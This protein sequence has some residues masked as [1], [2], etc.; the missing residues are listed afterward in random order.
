[1][2]T[3]PR[4]IHLV[5]E[6]QKRVFRIALDP[7]R[8]G[9]TLKSISM[10]AAVNYD[11]LR[12]YAAG[13]T[14]MPITALY[15]L[16]GVLPAELLSLLFPE[17]YSMVESQSAD[18]DGMAASAVDYIGAYTEARHPES[19]AGPDIGPTEAAKLCTK[20]AQMKGAA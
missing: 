14:V 13:E 2:T 7:M 4:I 3:D 12:Q 10:D 9:L 16:C 6:A 20:V 1:M 19:E 15:R 17:Q 5:K 18:L 11:S 8:Y